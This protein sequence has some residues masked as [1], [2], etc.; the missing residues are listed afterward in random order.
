VWVANQGDDTVLRLDL[1]SGR[2]RYIHVPDG[3]AKV[4][5]RGDAVWV[6]CEDSDRIARIDARTQRTVTP[7]TRLGGDPYGVVIGSG[8]L[9]VTLLGRDQV[10]RVADRR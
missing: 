8:V 2:T 5:V 10:A 1:R 6:T 7:T 3:P 9:W 4:A